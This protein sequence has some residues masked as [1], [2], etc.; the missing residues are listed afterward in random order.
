MKLSFQLSRSYTFFR[1]SVTFFYRLLIE[2]VS[3]E[4]HLPKT[5]VKS[6][7]IDM[8]QAWDKEKIRVL[9][10]NRTHNLPNPVRALYPLKLTHM[11]RTWD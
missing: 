10:R 3:E 1:C 8:I 6:D 7:L 2:S 9:D 4:C 5:S 11:T